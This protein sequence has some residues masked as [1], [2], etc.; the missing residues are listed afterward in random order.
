MNLLP[1]TYTE[2][3]NSAATGTPMMQAMAY[4]Y[5]GDS[6]AAVRD[7]Q[8]LYGR[9]LLVA[10]ITAQGAVSKDLYLPSGEWYDFWNG[11]RAM[12]GAKTYSAGLDTIPVYAKAGAIL[13]L[14]LNADYQLGGAISN[15]VDSYANLTFRVYP[16][17]LAGSYGY[18]DDAAGATKQVTQVADRVANTVTIG[19]PLSARRVPCR[20]RE[21]NPPR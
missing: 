11:G 12:G 19:L 17:S 16:S 8:Y 4:A 7:Q 2:A 3:A 13:P 10:P 21:P 18:F 5:P 6:Q 15:S 9:N 14:N 1:Y 20:C